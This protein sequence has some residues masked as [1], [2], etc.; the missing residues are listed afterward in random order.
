MGC[1]GVSKISCIF[2]CCVLQHTL[3]VRGVQIALLLLEI[4]TA[5]AVP[6]CMHICCCNCQM[7][8][9]IRFRRHA[10]CL[11]QRVQRAARVV[12]RTALLLHARLVASH[13][14]KMI[15]LQRRSL[16]AQLHR[17]ELRMAA[18]A[19]QLLV[20]LALHPKYQQHQ[21]QQELRQLQKTQHAEALA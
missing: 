5:Y 13:S 18:A 19:L 15:R 1:S 12:T 2:L 21:Q 6:S 16:S 9:H 7:L 17:A 20:V 10:L 14:Q 3:P 11:F 8:C 4:A